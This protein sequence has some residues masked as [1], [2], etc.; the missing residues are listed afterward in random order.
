MLG[1]RLF[2]SADA[3][4]V[5]RLRVLLQDGFRPLPAEKQCFLS[6]ISFYSGALTGCF[7]AR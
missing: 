3:L 6:L 1:F 5:M 2:F 7:T 4:Y